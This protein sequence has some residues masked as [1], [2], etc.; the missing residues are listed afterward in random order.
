MSKYIKNLITEHLRD[1]FKDVGDALLVNMVGLDANANNRLRAELRRK[2]IQ[3]LVVKNSLA[4]RAV[5]GTSLGAMFE[6]LAGSSAVCWGGEDIVSLAREITRL[7][8]DSQ[9]EAFQARG[10]VMDG[11]R[12]SGEEVTEVSTWPS[13]GEMLSRLVAQIL[14]PGARLAAQLNGPA[15]VLAG[16]I[17]QRAE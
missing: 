13:R 4:A 1:R 3:V 14:G 9:Y 17:A 16:Q 2:N 11:E 15:G 10:G 5:E 6:G 12:L 7:A 8:K